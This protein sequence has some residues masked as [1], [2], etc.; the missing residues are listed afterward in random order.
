MSI[1]F[2]G[3]GLLE[4]GRRK[5]LDGL[6]ERAKFDFADPKLKLQLSVKGKEGNRIESNQHSNQAQEERSIANTKRSKERMEEY[7]EKMIRCMSI[8]HPTEHPLLFFVVVV[9]LLLCV[10]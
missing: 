7:I 2:A 9:T 10:R 1:Q 4:C 5:G 3:S 8:L 6:I